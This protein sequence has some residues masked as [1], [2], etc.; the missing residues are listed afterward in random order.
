MQP[1]SSLLAVSLPV[2]GPAAVRGAGGVAG[3][4]VSSWTA[5]ISPQDARSVRDRGFVPQLVREALV[6]MR[7]PGQEVYEPS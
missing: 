1:N 4:V 6:P 7:F 3:T 5:R 2:S